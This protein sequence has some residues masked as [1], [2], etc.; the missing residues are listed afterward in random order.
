MFS[1]GLRSGNSL[2]IETDYTLKELNQAKNDCIKAMIF[3]KVIWEDCK[4]RLKEIS[5]DLYSIETI[6]EFGEQ[7]KRG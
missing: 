4:K 5:L 3:D 1:F 2:I 7:K 6:D